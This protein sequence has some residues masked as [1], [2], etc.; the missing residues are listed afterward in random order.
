MDA[1]M[2]KVKEQEAAM[3][4]REKEMEE[5]QAELIICREISERS[6]YDSSAK[7]KEIAAQKN[8]ILDVK[9][10]LKSQKIETKKY[11]DSF[12]VVKAQVETYERKVK[13]LT[14]L[15]ENY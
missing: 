10:D 9:E 3:K 14:I 11:K 7:V 6:K 13:N 1:Q 8:L 2:V 4:V 15:N 5:V 12:E